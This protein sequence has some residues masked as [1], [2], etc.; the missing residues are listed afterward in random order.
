MTTLEQA[1]H[2]GATLFTGGARDDD[3]KF[4]THDSTPINLP[5]QY[6]L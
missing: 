4:L 2:H 5:Q 6:W 3:R 1:L